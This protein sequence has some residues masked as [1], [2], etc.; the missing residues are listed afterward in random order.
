MIKNKKIKNREKNRMWYI[1]E[2]V[3]SGKKE[4]KK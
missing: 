4:Y 3:Q 1:E 2:M